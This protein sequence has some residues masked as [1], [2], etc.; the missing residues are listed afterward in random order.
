MLST[1][2]E[3]ESIWGR[4]RALAKVPLDTRR[5]LRGSIKE[6]YKIFFFLMKKGEKKKGAREEREKVLLL[7]HPWRLL[8]CRHGERTIRGGL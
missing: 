1:V 6:E 5:N 3:C 8:H 7:S 4:L 2:C